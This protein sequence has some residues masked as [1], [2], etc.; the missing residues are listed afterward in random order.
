MKINKVI[1][2]HYPYPAALGKRREAQSAPR[3]VASA[4]QPERQAQA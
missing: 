2:N 1:L 4:D 3:I